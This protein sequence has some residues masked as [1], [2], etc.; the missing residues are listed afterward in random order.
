M[1]PAEPPLLEHDT[2]GARHPKA[3][4]AGPP[5]RTAG[6]DPSPSLSFAFG[7]ALPAPDLTLP[8]RTSNGDWRGGGRPGMVA[9]SR[10][11]AADCGTRHALD[12]RSAGGTS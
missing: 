1:P 12:N 4:V 9:D 7:T 5:A 11:L 3:A 2:W 10:R 8:A 6:F